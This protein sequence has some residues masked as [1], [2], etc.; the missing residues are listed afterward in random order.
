MKTSYVSED[1]RRYLNLVIENDAL[2]EE[3][4]RAGYLP[5]SEWVGSMIFQEQE[6]VNLA[7]RLYDRLFR[8]KGA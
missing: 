7:N 1:Y 5:A 3:N 2:R 4:P 6:D 8:R